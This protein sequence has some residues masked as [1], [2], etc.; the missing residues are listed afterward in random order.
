MSG[1]RFGEE[2]ETI[3]R[4]SVTGFDDGQGFLDESAAVGALS[5]QREFSPD[6]CGTQSPLAGIVGWLDSLDVHNQSR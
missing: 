6:D 5:S 4:L 3:A 2:L 1:K